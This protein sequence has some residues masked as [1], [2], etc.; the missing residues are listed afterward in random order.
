MAL[1][2]TLRQLLFLREVARHGSMTHA[3]EAL[4]VSQPTVSSS[5]GE[6][7][8]QVGFPVF[9][10]LGRRVR[11]TEAGRILNEHGE[12]M[13][14][15]LGDADRALEALRGGETG[16]IVVGASSTPGIYLLP[17][18]LGAFKSRH[19]RVE[20]CLEVADTGVVLERVLQG[21]LDLGV[22]GEA[23]FDPLLHAERLLTDSLVLI[24]PPKHRLTARQQVTTAELTGEEFVLREAGSSTRRVLEKAL[25]EKGVALRTVMELGSA[26]AVKKSVAAGLGLSVVSEHAVALERQAGVL[27]VRPIADLDLNRGIYLVR[28]RSLRATPLQRAFLDALAALSQEPRASA[29]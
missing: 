22:V 24:L 10:R 27:A 17:P 1:N 26:E 7:E 18:L 12:R 6:L 11:L 3:G 14:A 29:K 25:A 16:Q 15:E 5:I 23:Q 28:R 2:V 4:H 19:P 9:E 13:L 20:V 21:K 8:R